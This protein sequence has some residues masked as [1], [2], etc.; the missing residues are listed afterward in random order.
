MNQKQ[1]QQF[2]SSVQ[3]VSVEK[4]S[5]DEFVVLVREVGVGSAP[6]LNR[7]LEGTGLACVPLVVDSSPVDFFSFPLEHTSKVGDLSST[8]LEAYEDKRLSKDE[9]VAIHK[10]ISSLIGFLSAF[11]DSLELDGV[12]QDG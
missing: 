2:A 11:K 12:F 10:K 3:D 4:L 1:V 9:K 5:L 8:L 7:L 6:V